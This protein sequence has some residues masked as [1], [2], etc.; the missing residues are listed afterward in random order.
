MAE[1]DF[2]VDQSN[3]TRWR[4]SFKIIG[5]RFLSNEAKHSFNQ[6]IKLLKC[7]TFQPRR[8]YI[9]VID[10]KDNLGKYFDSNLQLRYPL[11]N[12][13][14]LSSSKLNV[15]FFLYCCLAL[16]AFPGSCISSDSSIVFPHPAKKEINNPCSFP[17]CTVFRNFLP[18]SGGWK[19]GWRGDF[20]FT[21]LRHV[22]QVV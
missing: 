19:D 11:P 10:F 5:K 20:P 4:N 2:T 21:I 22:Y 8:Q 3:I 9:T 6:V 14:Q 7:S 15:T 13:I 18:V 16:F 12:Q 1:N 17:C